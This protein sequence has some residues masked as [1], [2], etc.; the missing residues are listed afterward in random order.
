MKT[1]EL[2]EKLEDIV[3]FFKYDISGFFRRTYE[4]ISRSI[5]FAKFGYLNHDFDHSYLF[6]LM[7]FKMKRIKICLEN[8]LA[9]QQEEDLKA[10]DEAISICDRLANGNYD[11]KYY[12]VLDIKW[13]ESEF[14]FDD[15]FKCTRKN[16]VTKEDHI[17][18]NKE[19]REA[20]DKA[21]ED[22]QADFDRLAIILKNHSRAW[23]W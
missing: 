20:M 12:S 8:G 10:L 3:D 17:Q 13:G 14:S 16:R 21:E 5:A 6:Q 9:E 15:G 1:L 11:D 4:R 2:K 18:Y 22:T 19:I 23:W 7:S